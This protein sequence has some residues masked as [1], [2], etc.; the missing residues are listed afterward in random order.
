MRTRLRLRELNEVEVIFPFCWLSADTR[1]ISASA[2]I[3]GGGGLL[4]RLGADRYC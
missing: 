4:D 2:L 3:G 1:R